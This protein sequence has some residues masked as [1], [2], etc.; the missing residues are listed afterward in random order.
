MN[1]LLEYQQFAIFEIVITICLTI[2]FIIANKFLI[3]NVINKNKTIIKTLHLLSKSQIVTSI[4]YIAWLKLQLRFLIDLETMKFL[5][6]KTT[7]TS[8][9]EQ[10]TK[11][12]NQELSVQINAKANSYLES[13]Q[14]IKIKISFLLYYLLFSLIISSFVFYYLL[15]LQAFQN[16]ALKIFNENQFVKNRSHLYAMISIKELYIYEYI[17]NSNKVINEIKNNVQQFIN[18]IQDEQNEIYETNIDQVFQMF[19]GNYCELLLEIMPNTRVDEYDSCQ[20]KLS[21]AFTRGLNQYHL[22]LSQI[23]ISLI[24]PNDKRYDQPTLN[25]LFEF[26]EVQNNAYEIEQLTLNLW[27]EQYFLYADNEMFLDILSICLMLF[28]TSTF[29]VFFIELILVKK[30]KKNYK[31][32]LKYIHRYYSNDVL[33]NQK[34]IRA[35]F[36]REGFIQK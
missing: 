32:T 3:M 19:Y 35:K 16:G 13:A 14:W 4:Q 23:A 9:C 7:Q 8:Y 29:Y 34:N 6:S 36:V 22:L 10:Q 5:N 26:S 31:Q 24:N 20:Y 21:G 15:F 27:C 12:D 11:Y 30:L 33:N 25:T 28:F 17:D 18:Q 1:R 2:F